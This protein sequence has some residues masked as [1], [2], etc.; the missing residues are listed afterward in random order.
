MRIKLLSKEKVL[1]KITKGL[2][3]ETNNLHKTNYWIDF[4]PGGNLVNGYICRQCLGNEKG[5]G[6]ESTGMKIVL[7]LK[8]D[9]DIAIKIKEKVEELQQEQ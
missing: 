8:K 9:N 3:K 1:A 5:K 2:L 6:V 4:K 7:C